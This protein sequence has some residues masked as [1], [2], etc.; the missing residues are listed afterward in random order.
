M[1]KTTGR[2]YGQSNER[3]GWVNGEWLDAQHYPA[4]TCVTT[5]GLSL[6]GRITV[7]D[8]DAV[9]VFAQFLAESGPAP[10]LSEDRKRGFPPGH[11]L[12]DPV[13][14]KAYTRR[15]MPYMLGQAAGPIEV[16]SDNA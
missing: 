14:R 7:G 15:W 6:P 3:P 11:P 10:V 5:G 2:S 9:R 4:P 13:A 8:A 12:H 1:D 16:S